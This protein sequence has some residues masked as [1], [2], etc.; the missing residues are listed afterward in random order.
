MSQPVKKNLESMRK[1]NK[2]F[3]QNYPSLSNISE[4]EFKDTCKLELPCSTTDDG[5]CYINIKDLYKNKKTYVY[6]PSLVN[7][8]IARSSITYI[9]TEKDKLYYRGYDIEDL[10]KNCSFVEVAYLLMN[11]D[12]PNEEECAN[13]RQ[14]LTKH[15]LVHEDMKNIFDTLPANSHPLANLA[16]M[17][18]TLSAYYS[19]TYEENIILGIDLKARLLSKIRTLAAWSYK[20]SIGHPFIY[21]L[22][23][24]DYISNFLRM[25]FCVPA[26]LYNVSPYDAKILEQSL[27]LYS[28]HEQNIAT[29]TVIFVGNTGANIFA[30]INAGINALWGMRDRWDSN[31]VSMLTQMHQE[32]LSAKEF[33]SEF[34]HSSTPQSFTTFGHQKYKGKDPRSVI[35]QKL[36]YEYIKEKKIQHP[37]IDKVCEIEDYLLKDSYC[38]EKNIYPNADFYTALIFYFLGIPEKMNDVMRLIGKLPGWL[39]HWEEHKTNY[40]TMTLRPQQLYEGYGPRK[41]IP[42]KDRS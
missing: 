16:T 7:V 26:M 25:M 17:I 20:K 28:D 3:S 34:I 19:G 9:D 21:P 36:F 8:A 30:S 10:V 14:L 18:T 24:L 41:F 37:I 42:M 27:M 38:I 13:Y 40:E 6:D 22:D 15:S 11:K 5:T 2:S 12:L 29:S 33:L 4:L 39:A 32:N 35:I 31:T 23:R 1:D